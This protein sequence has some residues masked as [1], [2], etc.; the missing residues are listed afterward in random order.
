MLMSSQQHP[1]NPLDACTPAQRKQLADYERLLL[2]WN[3]RVNLISRSTEPAVVFERHMLHSLALAERAFPDGCAVADF[4][5]GGGL[6]GIP[7]AIRFP[8]V[9]FH[10][11]DSTLKKLRAIDDMA[12]Q[13][14]L[15]NVHVHHTRAET[16]AGH[17]HY[18]VSR[19]TAPLN[20]L[21]RWYE[22]RRVPLRSELNEAHWTPGLLC[23]K[24]GDLRDEIARL[25]NQ[26]RYSSLQVTST[27]L[28]PLLGPS[29]FGEKVR[30]HVVDPDFAQPASR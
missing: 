12:T 22:R 5:T 3:T 2:D 14:G 4:G 24:G 9:T 23:L 21:W 13:L 30:L 8:A 27:P 17:A 19:A 1:W 28:Q 6:P 25:T 15:S 18:A 7:L 10:L 16:W 11:V 20:A 26:H 29:Y